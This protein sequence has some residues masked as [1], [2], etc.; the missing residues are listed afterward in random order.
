[1]QHCNVNLQFIY[2]NV[3][4][5]HVDMQNQSSQHFGCLKN[6]PIRCIT[7]L[8]TGQQF[9]NLLSAIGLLTDDLISICL[10]SCVI[11]T[12]SVVAYNFEVRSNGIVQ[13]DTCNSHHEHQTLSQT[14]SC[15]VSGKNFFKSKNILDTFENKKVDNKRVIDCMTSRTTAVLLDPRTDLSSG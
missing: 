13:I 12:S 8:L 15:Y 4:K 10:S 14:S 1:M 11:M 7:V 5:N 2:I 6:I 3:Q 9:I